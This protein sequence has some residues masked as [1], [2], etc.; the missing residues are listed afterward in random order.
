MLRICIRLNDKTK[1]IQLLKYSLTFI[2]FIQSL[3]IQACS[4]NQSS[5]IFHF[6]ILTVL[7]C[8]VSLAVWMK[9]MSLQRR[10]KEF[11]RV[12]DHIL[13]QQI[14]GR[15]CSLACRDENLWKLVE[16]RLKDTDAQEVHCLGLDTLREMEESLK[17]AAASAP[18]GPYYRRVRAR[19]GLRGLAKAFEVL[20]QA[21]LNMYLGPWRKEYRVI[22]VGPKSWND[23]TLVKYLYRIWHVYSFL[24]KMHS[25]TFTHYITP[26]L[27]MTQ[28]KRL[29]G[30][31]GY[32]PSLDQPEQLCLQSPKVNP[33]TLDDLLRLSCAFFVAR[34]ECQLLLSAL[35]NHVGDSQWELNMVRERQRGNRLQVCLLVIPGKLNQ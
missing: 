3:F 16:D 2:L 1:I 25:G 6:N 15:G 17:A 28:I 23:Q 14:V 9:E 12:Y 27:S 20:E 31:L 32:Q 13:E 10:A 8:S 19:G 34:C 35:W 33:A 21:A 7:F 26:V 5:S 4:I 22:K 11:V 24:F 18:P 29:F 30:L